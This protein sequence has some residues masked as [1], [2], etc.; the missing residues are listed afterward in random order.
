MFLDE[1]RDFRAALQA[2]EWSLCVFENA[3]IWSIVGMCHRSLGDRAKAQQ[4]FRKSLERKPG[5]EAWVLLFS[6]SDGKAER[7]ACLEKALELDP[8]YDEAHYFL[9]EQFR[10]DGELTLA[11]HHLELAVALDPNYAIAHAELGWTLFGSARTARGPDVRALQNAAVMHLERALALDPTL[12]WAN[13]YLALAFEELERPRGA[14]IHYEAAIRLHPNRALP[15]ALYGDFLSN[16]YG[17]ILLAEHHLRRAV[18]LDP[19]DSGAHF[20]LGKFLE[21]RGNHDEARRHLLRAE[22]LGRTDARA[23]LEEDDF[24]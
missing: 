9:G 18:E 4:A 7:R 5:A 11:R 2:A 24:E 23:V 19:E 10:L 16:R 14:K 15:H 21:R 3:L 17:N 6:V 22:E 8:N 1:L 13:L 20:H 12:Y